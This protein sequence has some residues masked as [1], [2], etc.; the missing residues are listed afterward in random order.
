[1]NRNGDKYRINLGNLPAGEYTYQLS[2]DLKGEVFVKKGVF[3]VRRQNIEL[4]HVVADFQLLNEIAETTGGQL[5]SFKNRESLVQLL[6][7]DHKQKPLYKSEAEF[8]DLSRIKISWL[9]LL[10]LLCIEW[11]LLKFFA[12]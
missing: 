12:D 5:T 11:F 8:I 3:Y 7:E 4:N 10:L 1:M 9:I 6:L 2:T